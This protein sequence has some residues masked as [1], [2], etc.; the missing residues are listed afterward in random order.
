MTLTERVVQEL[1]AAMLAKDAGR[2]NAL[3]MLKAAIGYAQV[4]K[5]TESLPEADVI[6]LIQREIK[7]RREAMEQFEK[8]GR[9]DLVD[10]ERGELAVLESFL[11]PPL[12]AEELEQLV[13]EAL[14]ETGASSRKQMG[15]VVKAVLA[16]AAGRADGKT[17]SEAVAKRLP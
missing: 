8:G 5:K 17:V 15:L 9:P 2:T 3:R 13:R 14:Q 10:K 6:A 12:A 16:K 11:P 1:K 7:R 4:E